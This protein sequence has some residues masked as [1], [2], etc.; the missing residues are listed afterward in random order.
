MKNIPGGENITAR[1]GRQIQH[2]VLEEAG[3]PPEWE[4]GDERGWWPE[5][6]LL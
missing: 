4:V 6:N 2:G 5:V 3:S 1:S